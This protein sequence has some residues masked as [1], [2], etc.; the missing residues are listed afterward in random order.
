M[1]LMDHSIARVKDESF[2]QDTAGSK[3]FAIFIS[4]VA[5]AAPKFI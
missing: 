1:R 2:E 5:Q 4:A 3:A